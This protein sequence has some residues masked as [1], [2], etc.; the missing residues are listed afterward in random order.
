MA[1]SGNS[2]IK[3]SREWLVGGVSQLLKRKDCL[4]ES[5]EFYDVIDEQ[6][7]KLKISFH[8]GVKADR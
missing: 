2:K 4:A 1:S 6:C 5:T 7:F 8:P 3:I